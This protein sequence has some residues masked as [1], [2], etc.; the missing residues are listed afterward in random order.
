[1]IDGQWDIEEKDELR[2]NRI[3]E[4]V[5]GKGWVATLLDNGYIEFAADEKSIERY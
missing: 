3:K 2:V 4:I 5:I 1:M